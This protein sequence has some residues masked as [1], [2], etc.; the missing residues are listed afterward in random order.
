MKEYRLTKQRW[1]GYRRETNHGVTDFLDKLTNFG[2]TPQGQRMFIID[3]YKKSLDE[4]DKQIKDMG[5]Y[6]GYGG[7]EER[8]RLK[9]ISDSLKQEM[10]NKLDSVS[11][12]ED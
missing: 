2:N 7:D 5:Q 8:K 12:V 10:V 9:N 1:N 11:V 6:E 4:I 3:G